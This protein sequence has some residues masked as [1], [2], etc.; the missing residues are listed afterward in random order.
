M[1]F[2]QFKNEIEAML[3]KQDWKTKPRIPE[4]GLE[5]KARF[6]NSATE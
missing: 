6:E 5:N 1:N 3:T 2:F 4:T